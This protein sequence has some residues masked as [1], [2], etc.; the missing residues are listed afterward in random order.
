MPFVEA[1]TLREIGVE[2]GDLIDEFRE[3][4][5]EALDGVRGEGDFRDENDDV[6]SKVER[7]LGRLQVDF[8]FPGTGDSVEKDGLGRSIR[9]EAFND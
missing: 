3:P 8:C 5:F 7:F 9:T 2:D 6:L 1:L 4:G